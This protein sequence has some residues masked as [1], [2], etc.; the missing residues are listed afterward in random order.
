M[1][2]VSYVMTLVWHWFKLIM[3][4]QRVKFRAVQSYVMNPQTLSSCNVIRHIKP[5]SPDPWFWLCC[6]VLFV[7]VSHKLSCWWNARMVGLKYFSADWRR[8]AS[9]SVLRFRPE[10][11]NQECLQRLS[12]VSEAMI[13]LQFYGS[14]DRVIENLS[15]RGGKIV[16]R[17][18]VSWF[19][20]RMIIG[21]VKGKEALYY[22]SYPSALYAKPLTLN[23]LF[24]H[25]AV[26]KT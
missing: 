24:S 7:H 3:T 8:Y 22:G 18:L 19:W 12:Q 2:L 4:F 23:C 16:F 13:M 9:I 25:W 10:L 6:G 20:F 15:I 17:F 26:N 5:S 21:S 11:N 14:M 1:I